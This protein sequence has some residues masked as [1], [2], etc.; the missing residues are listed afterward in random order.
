MDTFDAVIFC[1]ER[2][3]DYELHRSLL[4]AYFPRSV[5]EGI[6]ASGLLPTVDCDEWGGLVIEERKIRV[7]VLPGD[8]ESRARSESNGYFN[9]GNSTCHKL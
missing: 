7:A 8:H 9:R 3:E 1:M 2:E 4:P 5:E 6:A